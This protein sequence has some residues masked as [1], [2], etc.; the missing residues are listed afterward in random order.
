MW[1]RCWLLRAMD[2]LST[3]D[4]S[5]ESYVRSSNKQELSSVDQFIA[6]MV[7]CVCWM[8]SSSDDELLTTVFVV[9]SIT[10]CTVLC[11]TLNTGGTRI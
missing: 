3:D 2:L 1:L 11:E 10:V 9:S 6:V 4:L 5:R 8:L 7:Q